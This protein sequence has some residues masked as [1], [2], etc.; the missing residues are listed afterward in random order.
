MARGGP[1]ISISIYNDLRSEIVD[2]DM[3]SRT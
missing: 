3:I 2:E 1:K